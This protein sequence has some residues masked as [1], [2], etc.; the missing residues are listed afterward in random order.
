M[1]DDFKHRYHPVF[2]Q[3]MKKNPSL[4]DNCKKQQNK[5]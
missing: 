3:I 2:Y 1:F 5:N 4:E